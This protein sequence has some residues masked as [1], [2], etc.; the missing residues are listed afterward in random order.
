MVEPTESESK[1]ELD[2]FCD[3]MIAIREEIREIEEG[4]ADRTHNVLKRAPHTLE[5]V[6]ATRWDRPYTREKAAFPGALDAAPQVL[7]GGRPHRQRVRRSRRWCAPVRR[8]RPMRLLRRRPPSR[9]PRLRR[10]RSAR[11]VPPGARLAR[12]R[13]R[14]VPAH[15]AGRRRAYP[16]GHRRFAGWPHRCITKDDA[17]KLVE[18]DRRVTA[19]PSRCAAG[20][21]ESQSGAVSGGVVRPQGAGQR[22]A[23][24]FHRLDGARSSGID[25]GG[26]VVMA[27]RYS[28]RRPWRV[29]ATCDSRPRCAKE[30]RWRCRCFFPCTFECHKSHPFRETAF[31]T[32]ASRPSAPP[33]PLPLQR[34]SGRSPGRQREEVSVRR[35]TGG[36]RSGGGRPTGDGGRGA[37]G[38]RGPGQ[39]TGVGGGGV[40]GGRPHRIVARPH[41][42]GR[43]HARTSSGTVV[44]TTTCWRRSDGRRS[45]VSTA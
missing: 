7:A 41:R 35:H 9:R 40:G 21:A 11:A 3:A 34:V 12:A 2:R 28:T 14:R 30:R 26:G 39:P 6:V 4:R 16:V 8:S 31:C 33:L 42:D 36:G 38:G 13:E 37:G 10:W 25:S 1:E 15:P 27:S 29:R 23:A 5:Q 32:A 18:V 24:H 20:V 45:S 17:R 44:R 43:R 22:D 19:C